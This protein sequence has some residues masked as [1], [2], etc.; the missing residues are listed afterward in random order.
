MEEIKDSLLIIDGKILKKYDN[1]YYVSEYGDIYSTYCKR[2]LKHAIT[3]YGYHRVDIHGKHKYVHK[4]VYLTWIGEIP[5]GKQINHKD[6]N[7]DN[8]HFSNLYAGTQKE[9]I[10]D[11]IN[12]DHRCGFTYYLTIFDKKEN[13]VLTFCPAKKFIEYS[14]HSNKSGNLNKFFSKKWFKSRYDIIEFKRINNREELKSV[15]TMDDECNPVE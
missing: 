6:D 9:N 2:F 12:N 11:C 10:N 1:T 4:L 15:T 5:E 8:N 14:G 13:K 7:K 3:I